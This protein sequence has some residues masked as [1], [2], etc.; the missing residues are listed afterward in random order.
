MVLGTEYYI[1]AI[2]SD[3]S[4][5]EPTTADSP[6]EINIFEDDNDTPILT[7]AMTERT[8]QTGQYRVKIDLTTANGFEVGKSYAVR[9]SSVVGGVTRWV[10]IQ[11]FII[12]S[13]T[14]LQVASTLPPVPLDPDFVPTMVL[15]EPINPGSI[16]DTLGVNSDYEFKELVTQFYNQETKTWDTPDVSI[17]PLD[18]RAEVAIQQE[19]IDVYNSQLEEYNTEYNLQKEVQWRLHCAEKLIDNS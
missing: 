19:S 17:V 12:D 11:N 15:S 8:G 3:P 5:G 6:P 7:T 14:P 13:M 16:D 4:T 18:V 9:V 2:V 1:D 10:I